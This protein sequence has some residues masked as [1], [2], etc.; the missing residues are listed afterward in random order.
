[1]CVRLQH[2]VRSPQRFH[3]KF[4]QM[5]KTL[6]EGTRDSLKRSDATLTL[7][8][9][10]THKRLVSQRRLVASCIKPK[11]TYD[12]ICDKTLAVFRVRGYDGGL[13]ITSKRVLGWFNTAIAGTNNGSGSK[14]AGSYTSQPENI[15]DFNPCCSVSAQIPSNSTLLK[16]CRPQLNPDTKVILSNPD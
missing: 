10:V 9:Y 3:F 5:D 11:V 1:M 16:L 2:M 13:L 12:V 14:Q 6:E 15:K 4:T 7:C 8:D